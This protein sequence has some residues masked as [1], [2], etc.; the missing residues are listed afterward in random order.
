MEEKQPLT[1]QAVIEFIELTVLCLLL[2]VH[3]VVCD[4]PVGLRG[5]LPLEDDLG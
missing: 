3:Q 5:R 4:V 2:P 1:F